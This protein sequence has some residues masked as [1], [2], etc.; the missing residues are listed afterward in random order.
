M[1][2]IGT[3]V[4]KKKKPGED[5]FILEGV[6]RNEESRLRHGLTE[7]LEIYPDKDVKI[8]GGYIQKYTLGSLSL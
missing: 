8:I 4:K 3:A 5:F 2:S 6:V 1:Y 7:N